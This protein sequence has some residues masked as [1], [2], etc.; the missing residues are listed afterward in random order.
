M[1]VK[2]KNLYLYLA[3]ACFLGVILIFIFDGYMGVYDT[4]TVKTGEFP[5]TIEPEQ[6]A[7]RDRYWPVSIDWGSKAAFSYEVENRWFSTYKADFEVSVWHEQEK[8]AVLLAQ[9]IS[10]ASFDKGQLEWILNTAELVPP[11]LPPEQRYN[12][13]VVIKRGDIERNILVHVSEVP[14]PV[15]IET[16][17]P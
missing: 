15:I 13:T 11:D 2:Y 3:L 8:V 14:K 1:T 10:I 16:Q 5:Q 9:P 7:Q 17:P 4:L 6:W 12:F